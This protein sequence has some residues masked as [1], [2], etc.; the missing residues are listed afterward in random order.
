[1]VKPRRVDHSMGLFGTL[2]LRTPNHPNPLGL[3]LVKLIKIEGNVV[4]VDKLDAFDGTPVI[5]IKPYYEHDIILSPTMPDIRHTDTKQ[6]EISLLELAINYHQDECFGMALAIKMILAV[7]AL[8]VNTGDDSTVLDVTGGA[9][10]ADNLQGLCRARLSNPC[11]FIFH[12]S[13]QVSVIWKTPEKVITVAAK[14]NIPDTF[15]G[16]MAKDPQD[17]FEITE[18]EAKQEN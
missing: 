6:R 7:E 18:E 12:L 13:K 2:A 4:H 16:V 5:D 11:R 8:G 14:P 15:D 1:M 10:L 3:T 17:L 9:C